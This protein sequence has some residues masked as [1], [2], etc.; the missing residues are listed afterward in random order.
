[1]VSKKSVK[2]T[3]SATKAPWFFVRLVRVLVLLVVLAA[4]DPSRCTVERTEEP[5]KGP[6][7]FDK[8]VMPLRCLLALNPT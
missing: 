1:M 4:G 2:C 3:H 8:N 5:F 6:A 7:L